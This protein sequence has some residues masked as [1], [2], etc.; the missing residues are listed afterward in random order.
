[1]AKSQDNQKVT[2]PAGRA[3]QAALIKIGAKKMKNAFGTGGGYRRINNQ[4]AM[5]REMLRK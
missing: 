2:T 4:E 3:N 1:M 5:R